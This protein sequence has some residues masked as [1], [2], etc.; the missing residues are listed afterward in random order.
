MAKVN[1]IIFCLNSVNL[2]GQGVSANAILSAITPEYIP[3]LFTFSVIVTI[4]DIDL[5]KEPILKIVFGKDEDT[6]GVIEGPLPNIEDTSNLPKEYRGINLSI[7]MNNTNFKSDGL[8]K[9]S[10]FL[11]EELL[12]EKE[13]YVKGKNQ[14]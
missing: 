8:Y 12:K 9:L 11:N 1:D 4:L 5:E 10:V 14:E 3:G 2:Q 7:D 6:L 13:I